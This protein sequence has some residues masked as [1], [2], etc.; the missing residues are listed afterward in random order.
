M[1]GE[2]AAIQ[3]GIVIVMARR[4]ISHDPLQRGYTY[5]CREP[6]GR[7]FDAR[8]TPHLTPKEMLAL[9]VFGGSYFNCDGDGATDEYPKTWFTKAKQSS[10]GTEDTK[11]N[12]FG[13]SASQS[14]D[15]WRQKGW[16]AAE[17]PRGWVQW[18]FRYYLGR[19]I[20]EEDER[21]IKRWAAFRRHATALLHNCARRDYACRPRQRQA[22]LHWAYDSTNM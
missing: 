18:Y 6:I 20:P 11:L 2:G 7:H 10:D 8:F 17:D 14:R 15:V 5:V 16:I 21:Q 1:L 3:R 12:F 19:R 22:L 4:I 13:V 9:G